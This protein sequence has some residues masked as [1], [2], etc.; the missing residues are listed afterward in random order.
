MFSQI[1]AVFLYFSSLVLIGIF[2]RQKNASAKDFTLGNRQL[3]F[4]VTAISAHAGDMSSWLFM[5]YPMAIFIAGGTKI[6]LGIG[7]VLGMYSS[8]TVIAPRLRR[9]TEE[10]DSYTLSTFF[11]KRFN[12]A[13]GII[14]LLSAG[15]ILFFMTYYVSAGLVAT[16]R[17]F[18]S[19]FH[20]DYY[21]GITI[22]TA[23]MLSYMYVGGF[24]SVAWTDFIQGIFLLVALAI[25]PLIAFFQIDNVG[26]IV[27]SA[28]NRGISLSIFPELSF[29][30]LF[31][32][33]SLTVGWGLGYF[34]QP[35]ILTKFMAIKNPNDLKKSKYLGIAWQITV[36]AAASAVAYIG[37]AFFPDGL[38]KPEMVFVEMTKSVFAPFAVI[39]TI[40]GIF[41]ANLSTMDSQILV[42]ATTLS[43]DFYK[44]VIKKNASSKE[45]LWAS[46]LGILLFSGIAFML[47]WGQ[48]Q[49][50]MS[51][52][53]YAWSGLGGAF[54]P[55]LIVALYSKIRTPY[56][57]IAGI[58]VGSLSAAIWPT[59]NP[60]ITDIAIIPLFPAFGCSLSAIFTV[61]W[62]QRSFKRQ[63]DNKAAALSEL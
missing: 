1:A 9:A 10:Y 22:A 24:V 23:I 6:W 59:I 5:A 11:E 33:F 40:C 48:S 21:I 16:G 8:W 15:V 25:V 36:L 37:F 34:G 43:E 45:V 3:N 55:L 19:L 12:D 4:W 32:I 17:L 13:S 27:A 47:A 62:L 51:I 60:L 38:E 30:S 52:V 18:D 44:R 42:C 61:A 54:G 41:A 63:S 28:Q 31:S 35:H 39:F 57:A 2:S 58:A 56:A 29:S 20:I 7:L 46:K 50:I 49:T 14:R 53:E 26:D